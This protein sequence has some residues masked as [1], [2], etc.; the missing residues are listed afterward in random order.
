LAR[1]RR[2]KQ[3]RIYKFR[4]EEHFALHEKTA[5]VLCESVNKEWILNFYFTQPNGSEDKRGKDFVWS[6]NPGENGETGCSGAQEK[7]R[8]ADVKVHFKRYPCVPLYLLRLGDSLE[9]IEYVYL[10]LFLRSR[11]YN[12]SKKEEI[13]KRRRFL[14]QVKITDADKDQKRVWLNWCELDDEK[15]DGFID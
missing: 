3:N 9:R 6:F 5:H 11:S 13:E 7:T 14:E 15:A 10:T 12:F 4:A 8:R 1:K 2:I